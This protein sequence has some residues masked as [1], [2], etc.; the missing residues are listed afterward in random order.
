MARLG[1][2]GAYEVGNVK[3]ILHSDNIKEKRIT[4]KTRQ[5]ISQSKLGEANG[6]AVLTAEQVLTLRKEF[7][8]NSRSIASLARKHKLP[9]GAVYS[10]V[11]GTSW[12]HL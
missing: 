3:I 12:K 9:Y 6:M 2:Q 1:D 8:P 7:K 11:T 10:V 5:L 4:N